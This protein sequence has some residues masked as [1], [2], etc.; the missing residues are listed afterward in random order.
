MNPVDT[1]V[2]NMKYQVDEYYLELQK[3]AQTLDII[4]EKSTEKKPFPGLRPFRTTEA[5]L[6]FGREGLSKD[7]LKILLRQSNFLAVL[8]ASGSGKSSLVRAGLIPNLHAGRLQKENINWRIVICR[9]GNNP[10]KNL[11]A[12]F[13]SAKMQ[14]DRT[15]KLEYNTLIE[16]IYNTLVSSS[17]GIMEVLESFD[18]SYERTLI[19]IDQFEELFRFYSGKPD[20]KRNNKKF[21]NLLLTATEIQDSPVYTV[22]TMRS[23][24]LGECVKFRNLPEA[25]NKGQYLIPR[26]TSKNIADAIEGPISVVG[27]KIS[28]SLVNR[29]IIEVGDDMD[30]LPVLQHALMRTYNLAMSRPEDQQQLSIEDYEEIGTMQKALSNHATTIYNSLK[31]GHNE[32]NGASRKQKIAKLIFQRLTDQTE[33]LKGGRYPTPLYKM[34]AITKEKPLMATKAEVDEVINTFREEDTSF[35]MPPIDTP[36]ND[37]LVIDISHESLMRNWNLLIGSKNE[38]GWILEEIENGKRYLQ[39]RERRIHEDLITSNL[40]D[41]LLNWEKSNC[42]GPVWAKRY[43]K[44]EGSEIDFEENINFLNES[45]QHRS[46]VEQK[47]SDAARKKRRNLIGFSLAGLI[48]L[49]TGWTSLIYVFQAK[50]DLENQRI[51]SIFETLKRSNPTL[52]YNAVAKWSGDKVENSKGEIKGELKK[53]MDKFDKSNSYLV[54][55]LPLS[56]PLQSIHYNENG[57]ITLNGERFTSVWNLNKGVLIAR[58]PAPY[59]NYDRKV[60]RTLRGTTTTYT[61][62]SS[63]DGNLQIKDTDGKIVL[64]YL[65]NDI[66]GK[67]ASHNKVASNS[68]LSENGRYAFVGSQIF[69]LD[70]EQKI[71]AEIHNR[72]TLE[73]SLR[74]TFSISS[75]RIS[76]RILA[77]E[78]QLYFMNDNQHAVVAYP[79]GLIKIIRYDPTSDN[80]GKLVAAF[81]NINTP[82]ERAPISSIVI[83]TSSQYVIARKK[84]YTVDVWNF[85]STKQANLHDSIIQ[86]DIKKEPDYVLTG[87]TGEIN[88]MKISPD[89]NYLLTGAEDNLAMLWDIKTG[90]RVSILRGNTFPIKF[91]DFSDLGEFMFTSDSQDKFSVWKWEEPGKITSLMKISPFEFYQ[92]GIMANDLKVDANNVYNINPIADSTEKLAGVVFHYF[93]SLPKKNLFPEDNHYSEGIKKALKEVDT[94]FKYLIHKPDFKERVS[95][96]FQELLFKNHELVELRKYDLEFDNDSISEH[97]RKSILNRFA[98][99]YYLKDSTNNHQASLKYARELFKLNNYSTFNEVEQNSKNNQAIEKVLTDFVA[100]TRA[101][102]TQIKGLGEEILSYYSF[103]KNYAQAFNITNST[104]RYQMNDV[105]FWYSRSWYA[106]FANEYKEAIRSAKKTMELSGADEGVNTNLALGYLLDGQWKEAE[107]I[108][109]EWKNREFNNRPRR[110]ANAIFLQDLRDLEAK[111]ITHPDFEKVRNILK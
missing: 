58:A 53:F 5:H 38:K 61:M 62:V 88:C 107:L 63:G 93:K 16:S 105:P 8:G 89:N 59:K 94:L 34:Y 64:T 87:H 42:V 73:N 54:A 39:L 15:D 1:N 100:T 80:K 44:T 35:L 18:D 45:K 65:L 24:F 99:N 109:L 4:D 13:A 2:D 90:E 23:E 14:T 95:A 66:Y 82:E 81:R 51:L 97:S 41:D 50:T 40:L 67:L 49:I 57:N 29:M 83:D 71:V 108:Y 22:I 46:E 85:D 37:N 27:K 91:A 43:V 96:P 111:G 47:K 86:P 17:Y 74:D 48:L 70:N 10:L 36:L 11:A 21:V 78:T 25:I 69:D 92:R 103:K 79:S 55:T 106:L 9:P 30:Q 84:D 12:A 19:I 32:S 72:D 98:I 104:K 77:R 56:G 76:S 3:K 6:F 110:L 75:R 31:N 33:G 102:S 60:L 28:K 52:S 26:L 101:D 7:L 68:K 20:S